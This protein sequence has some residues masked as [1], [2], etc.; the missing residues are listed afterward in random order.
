MWLP[1]AASWN[2][3]IDRY[4]NPFLPP[5]PWK[6][7]PYPVSWWFGYRK[8][9]PRALG[10]I[11]IA[12]WSCIGIF[13][14]ILL[15]EGVSRHVQVFRDHGAPIIVA[16]FVSYLSSLFGSPVV[17]PLRAGEEVVKYSFLR[18]CRARALYC[19]FL[20]SNHLW[21]SLEALSWANSSPQSSG[22]VLPSYLP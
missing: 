17:A 21:R 5:P 9:P 19:T 10:N 13:C 3:D 11:L 4:L 2:I 22:S 1:D 15:I 6:Y 7:L 20:L 18:S 16:S 12:F 14:A 8:N